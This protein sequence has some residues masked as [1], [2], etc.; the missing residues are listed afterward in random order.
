MFVCNKIKWWERENKLKYLKNK[1]FISAHI[2]TH[3]KHTKH[4][5]F[6]FCLLKKRKL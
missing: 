4:K 1:T 6:K 2:H 3:K 5:F